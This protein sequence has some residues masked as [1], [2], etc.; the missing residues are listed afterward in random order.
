MDEFNFDG[1]RDVASNNFYSDDFAHLNL[2]DKDENGNSA[3]FQSQDDYF[4]SVE[5]DTADFY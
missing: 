5:D 1:L 2:F 4:D 3:L